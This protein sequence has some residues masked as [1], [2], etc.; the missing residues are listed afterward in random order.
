MKLT[1]AGLLCIAP[2]ALSQPRAQ[3]IDFNHH[4]WYSYSGDHRV[5]G[6]WGIHI[7]GQWRRADFGSEWQQYQIRPG[8]NVALSRAL[9]L[10]FGYAFTKTYPYGDF[11]SRSSFPEH[12]IYQ[13]ALVDHYWRSLPLQHRVRLEQRFLRYPDPEPA[14]WT[15]QNRFRY[16]LR[17]EFPIARDATGRA[18]WYLPVFNE[19]LIGIPPNYGARPFDQNRAFLGIGRSLPGAKVEIG[20]LNQFIGQRNG[21]IFESNNTLFV[22]V[23]SDA[24]LSG[25]WRE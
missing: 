9:Q 24:S 12:R 14:E 15:Y 11:P 16:M 7:D 18:S 8:V 21:R 20:Y 6:P 2:L 5:S 23:T 3:L 4:T 10:T 17:T 1:L 19:L 13:Q 22:T 25:W